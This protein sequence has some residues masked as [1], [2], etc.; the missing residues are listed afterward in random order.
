V[1]VVGVAA[2]AIGL[3]VWYYGGRE[4]ATPAPPRPSPHFRDTSHPIVRRSTSDPDAATPPSADVIDHAMRG[5]VLVETAAS[6][7]TGFFVSSD[8][9]ATTMHVMSKQSSATIT[10]QDGR[11]RDAAM[12]AMA[13]TDDFVLLRVAAE[14]PLDVG[15]PFGRSM[16]L[17][18][19]QTVVRLSWPHRVAQGAVRSLRRDERRILVETDLATEPQAD[20]A[21][22][23]DRGGRVVGIVTTSHAG[24]P[25]SGFAISYESAAPSFRI[26]RP[27]PSARP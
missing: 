1:S 18:N 5:V 10:T 27:A 14:P 3:G 6:S 22:L 16:D 25:S 20:G 13:Y 19:G 2:A 15:L 7:G 21:P 24:G 12:A 9:I 11:Q 23:I 17:R 26:L 4:L 8:V